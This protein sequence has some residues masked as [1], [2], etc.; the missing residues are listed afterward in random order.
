MVSLKSVS[1]P[2]WSYDGINIFFPALFFLC[3]NYPVVSNRELT[4]LL[5]EKNINL[6]S[7]NYTLIEELYLKL[8]SL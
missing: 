2:V 6:L 3:G 1:N 5:E 7:K 4:Q 8:Q